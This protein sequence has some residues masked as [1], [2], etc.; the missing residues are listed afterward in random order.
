MFIM[1]KEWILVFV[2]AYKEEKE[3]ERKLKKWD[4]EKKRFNRLQQSN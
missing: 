2:Y 4:R 3:M 1:M